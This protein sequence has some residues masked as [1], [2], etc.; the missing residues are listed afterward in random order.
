MFGEF[1]ITNEQWKRHFRGKISPLTGNMYRSQRNTAAGML[2]QDFP[3]ETIKNAYFYRYG[4][5]QELME[6]YKKFSSFLC[7]LG[8]YY[9]QPLLFSL[10]K[11]SALCESELKEEFLDYRDMYP[12]DGLVL[13]INDI[14]LWKKLGRHETSGNPVYAI[15]YKPVDF[16]DTFETTVKGITWKISKA[17]YLKPVVNIDTVDTG[18]CNMENPTGYNAKFIFNNKIAEGAK[19]LVTRSGGVIP[20]ILQ[21]IETASPYNMSMLEFKMRTCPDCIS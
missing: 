9:K 15:A 10:Y 20:K 12:V 7:D 18:D 19:V 3:N 21:T 17:G 11:A 13:Y 1:I 14:S 5:S 8:I 4:S 16:Q 2:N 6:R